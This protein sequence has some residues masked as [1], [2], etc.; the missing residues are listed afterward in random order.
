MPKFLWVEA[1]NIVVDI[2]NRIPHKALGN[3]TPQSVF[4]GSKQEVSHFRVFSSTTYCHVPNE[5]RKKLDMTAEK[6]YLVGYSENAK[7]YRIYIPESRKVVVQRDVKIIEE[8]AF[9]KS[10][11]M[12]SATQSK[13]DP[14]VQLQRPAKGNTSASPRHG[15]PRDTSPEDLQEGEQVDPPTTSGR[16]SR[17]LR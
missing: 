11:E 3:I 4:T 12:P 14:L 9:R 16:T 13:E 5:K 10:R 8:R 7:A 15:D 2:H 17:E 1:C 6:G